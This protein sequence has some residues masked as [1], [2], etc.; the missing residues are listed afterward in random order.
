MSNKIKRV[1]PFT[2]ERIELEADVSREQIDTG[3]VFESVDGV[4]YI[5]PVNDLDSN[6]GRHR[7]TDVEFSLS[8]Q[9][10]KCK[11]LNLG[12][13]TRWN[14]PSESS[15]NITEE[16][17]ASLFGEKTIPKQL[18]FVDGTV[19]IKGVH[20]LWYSNGWTTYD[21]IQNPSE[22]IRAYLS[23]IKSLH[24]VQSIVGNFYHHHNLVLNSDEGQV[25]VLEAV[26]E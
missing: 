13:T 19:E 9:D 5:L 15:G 18:H 14:T 7:N 17:V 20:S 21:Y 22:E 10:G 23:N 4:L 2:G 16:V 1:N 24:L 3:L 26:I 12:E 8:M 6:F 25:T 11:S